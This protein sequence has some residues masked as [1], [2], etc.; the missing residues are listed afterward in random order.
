MVKL[1]L[2]ASIA[3]VCLG[4]STVLATVI[5]VVKYRLIYQLIGRLQAHWYNCL[6]GL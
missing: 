3:A 2:A 5:I 6:V 1:K 4:S